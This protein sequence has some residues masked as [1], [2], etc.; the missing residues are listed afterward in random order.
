M[1]TYQNRELMLACLQM[2]VTLQAPHTDVD[3]VIAIA[4]RLYAALPHEKPEPAAL[5]PPAPEPPAEIPKA[6]PARIS[7]TTTAVGRESLA[8][9]KTAEG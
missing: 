2:A 6:R 9:N 8:A 7:R 3:G 4:N 5:E 1:D